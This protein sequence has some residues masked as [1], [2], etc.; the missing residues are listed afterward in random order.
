[1][2]KEKVDKD[3]VNEPAIVYGK[4]SINTSTSFDEMENDQLRYFASLTPE[5]LLMEHKKLSI[6]A[7]GIKN[8]HNKSS[9]PDRIIKYND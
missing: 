8:N 7:Y 1:M 6:V 5:Q 3:I 4:R 2:K 9:K